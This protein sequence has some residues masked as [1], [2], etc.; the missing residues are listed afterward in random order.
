M[1]WLALLI[2]VVGHITEIPWW[3]H[4]LAVLVIVMYAVFIGFGFLAAIWT[5]KD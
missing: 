1:F 3:I 2:L 4:Q 5:E